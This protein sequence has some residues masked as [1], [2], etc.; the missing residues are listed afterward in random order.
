MFTFTLML[1]YLCKQTKQISYVSSCGGRR[2]IIGAGLIF[3]YLCSQTLKKDIMQITH[4]Y[5]IL[6]ST[7]NESFAAAGIEQYLNEITAN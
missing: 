7:N 2:S 4:A 1:W 6:P 3:I 5:L